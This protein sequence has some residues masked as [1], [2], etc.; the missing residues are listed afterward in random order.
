[1]RLP[2]QLAAL[3]RENARE[4]VAELLVHPEEVADFAAAHADVARRDVGVGADVAEE[5]AHERLAE[6]HDFVVALSLRI[7]IAAALAAAH[8]ERREGVLEHLLEGEELEDAEVDARMEAEPALV[9]TDGAVHLDAE[10]A[11]D[12]NLALVVHPGHTEH[13][14]ALGFADALEDHV[15]LIFGILLDEG[16]ERADD[17]EH[18]LMELGLIRIARLY[19]FHKGVDG[20]CCH[21]RL[22]FRETLKM[23]NALSGTPESNEK[24]RNV[25]GF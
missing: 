21:T 22:L 15:L 18:G 8:G 9:G 12:L 1:M 2:P 6:R 14:H 25:A 11:V 19:L 20:I 23:K 7:E 24:R 13:D 5:L 10:A 16:H 4:L 3:A 17:L